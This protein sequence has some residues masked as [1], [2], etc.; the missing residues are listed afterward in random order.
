MKTRSVCLQKYDSDRKGGRGDSGEYAW[1][2][3]RIS[4]SRRRRAFDLR[5][6]PEPI[7]PHVQP[8]IAGQRL[9]RHTRVKICCCTNR[10]GACPFQ[11]TRSVDRNKKER[12]TKDRAASAS[13]HC[14]RRTTVWRR[15][16]HQLGR[17]WPRFL[18]SSH[19]LP[20]D[21]PC[22]D[23]HAPDIVQTANRVVVVLQRGRRGHRSREAH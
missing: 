2:N 10:T 22:S 19:F 7:A 1:Y 17:Y 9:S 15:V 13:S 6:S 18:P 11:R 14:I 5:P 3:S 12:R 16:T 23:G 21:L 8:R 4:A 20:S